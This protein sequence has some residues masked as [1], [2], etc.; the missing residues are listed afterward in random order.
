M[1]NPNGNESKIYP[2]HKYK[3]VFFFLHP[4]SVCLFVWMI[5]GLFSIFIVLYH[6]V[7]WDP[8]WSLFLWCVCVCVR[9]RFQRTAL[10]SPPS[11]PASCF[12][13]RQLSRLS[14]ATFRLL[15]ETR[16]LGSASC[17]RTQARVCLLVLLP[18]RSC[19]RGSVLA[20]D[21]SV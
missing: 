18:L 21:H 19:I 8:F 13:S 16:S 17:C 7:H 20:S 2:E 6:S 15:T 14:H 11:I 10:R 9:F 1:K 12:L 3:L 5:L 4:V